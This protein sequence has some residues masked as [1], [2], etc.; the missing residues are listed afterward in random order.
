[1]L[2]ERR[3]MIFGVQFMVLCSVFAFMTSAALAH[4]HHEQGKKGKVYLVGLGTGDMGNMTIR[5]RDTIAEADIIFAMQGVR[6]AYATLLTGKEVHDAGHG[7][8]GM[9]H[10]AEKQAE[11]KGA[12][13]IGTGPSGQQPVGRHRKPLAEIQKQQDE[14]RKII[15]E[16][17][18]A[19]KTIAILDNGDPTIFGPHIGY[20]REFADLSP[21]VIPGLSSFNAANAALKR[22]VTRGSQS[23]S[24]I[25]TAARG[26]REG[27]QGKDSLAKLAESQ[28]TLVFY[29]M[30]M[31]LAEVVDVLKK[32]Y[33]ADTPLAIVF[34]AGSKEKERV[35]QATLDT[36]LKQTEGRDLPFE[37]LI[38][39]GDFLK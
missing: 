15:R 23:S 10:R 8:F 36:V 26:A 5:A 2:Y 29:T 18:A 19:G 7:L 38:Y 3:K 27:Y 35:L 34:H 31:N 17:V 14:T 6:E 16:G 37:H 22:D 12:K 32:S 28:S 25:L 1:M 30:G 39:V 13:D 9:M 11:K 20:L 4:P 24:V 33:P 21:V